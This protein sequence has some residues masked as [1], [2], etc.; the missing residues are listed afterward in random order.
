MAVDDLLAY[1][2]VVIVIV[3]G[4]VGLPA[5]INVSRLFGIGPAILLF[6][7]YVAVIWIAIK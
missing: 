6:G 3:W 5:A 4:L 2:R 7:I 1:W